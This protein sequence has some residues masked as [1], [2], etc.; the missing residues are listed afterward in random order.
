MSVEI[1]F[2]G[3][4]TD[5][6]RCSTLNMDNPGTIA[7]LKSE[8]FEKFPGLKEA[9]FT[10]ALNNKLAIENE[11]IGENATIALMPPFSGG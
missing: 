4:L 3:Q 9:K 7:V 6:T 10:I 5:K 1:L 2:F 11:L 8:L